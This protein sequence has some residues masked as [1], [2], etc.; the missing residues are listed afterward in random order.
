MKFNH[1]SLGGQTTTG[2]SE[3]P[4][5]GVTIQAADT[6]TDLF[7]CIDQPNSCF[8]PGTI[9]SVNCTAIGLIYSSTVSTFLNG[10]TAGWQTAYARH[11]LGTHQSCG[12][13]ELGVFSCGNN[14]HAGCRYGTQGP[15]DWQYFCNSGVAGSDYDGPYS[16]FDCNT[17]AAK[18]GPPTGLWGFDQWGKCYYSQPAPHA[19]SICFWNYVTGSPTHQSEVYGT[20]GTT[21]RCT[22]N[23]VTQ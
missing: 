10:G 12:V 17:N 19:P 7:S 6:T 9:G 23:E 4:G 2:P 21:G 15:P 22:F 3:A 5:S 13:A 8:A 1:G 16:I 18:N 11:N 20:Y 14:G